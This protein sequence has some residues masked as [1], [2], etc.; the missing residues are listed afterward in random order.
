MKLDRLQGKKE[1]RQ[2]I[3]EMHQLDEREHRNDYS[4]YDYMVLQIAA[5]DDYDDYYD[6]HYEDDRGYDDDYLDYDYDMLDDSVRF[7]QRHFP[8]KYYKHKPTGDYIFVTE[9][10]NNKLC[11]WFVKTGKEYL[12]PLFELEGEL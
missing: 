7:E 11:Y 4:D 12:G 10:H 6:N 8:G 3:L 2:Q 5:L 9:N 1:L